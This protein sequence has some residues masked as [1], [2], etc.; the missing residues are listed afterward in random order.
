MRHGLRGF[1]AAALGALGVFGLTV[2]AEAVVAAHA[3]AAC[4]APLHCVTA[5]CV[6]HAAVRPTDRAW[7]PPA[8]GV[9]LV[10]GSA[11]AEGSV[12]AA[13]RITCVVTQDGKPAGGCNMRLPG[14]VSACVGWASVD[15]DRPYEV[16]AEGEAMWVD[17]GA[18][19]VTEICEK[20]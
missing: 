6:A 3:A 2:R 13:T 7:E 9:A 1:L 4:S 14:Q 8:R 17:G 12:A 5:E 15:V 16:C 11:Q 10:T 19:A 20:Y 18:D